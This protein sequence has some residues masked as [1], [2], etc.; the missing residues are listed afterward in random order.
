MSSFV[1]AFLRWPNFVLRKR[2]IFVFGRVLLQDTAKHFNKIHN[3]NILIMLWYLG[4]VLIKEFNLTWFILHPNWHILA[5]HHRHE[6]WNRQCYA[7]L[8]EWDNNFW[9]KILYF[10]CFNK[11]Q[12]SPSKSRVPDPS[13]STSS[14]MF[15]K[16]S[17]V[18]F[19]SSSF[20]I[21]FKVVVEINPFPNHL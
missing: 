17:S 19:P 16:S 13:S 9:Y 12:D 1:F 15:S 8:Y 4:V 6:L 3:W 21:S 20:K 5:R 2:A 7:T 14:M 11:F 18:S 10:N